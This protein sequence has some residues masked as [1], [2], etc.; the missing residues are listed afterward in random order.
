MRKKSPASLPTA[1]TSLPIYTCFFSGRVSP[2]QQGRGGRGGGGSKE[3]NRV[4]RVAGRGT[5]GL[6]SDECFRMWIVAV[7]LPTN[8]S[9]TPPTPTGA[10][11]LESKRNC[12]PGTC[13]LCVFICMLLFYLPASGRPRPSPRRV[14]RGAAHPLQQAR[15]AEL[16]PRSR[17]P[18]AQHAIGA[19]GHEPRATGVRREGP[20]GPRVPLPANGDGR[21]RGLIAWRISGEGVAW[22]SERRSRSK[23]SQGLALLFVRVLH[24]AC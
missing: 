3:S 17:V 21:V 11:V 8:L 23:I 14:E 19:A 9:P 16:P 13:H 5:A 6:M 24:A 18:Q 4:R 10:L 2:W 20:A 22:V 15:G 12:V 7:G 1:S